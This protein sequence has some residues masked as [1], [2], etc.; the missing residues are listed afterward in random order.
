MLEDPGKTDN[1][2]V[3]KSA[4]SLSKPLTLSLSVL[5]HQNKGKYTKANKLCMVD[6][7]S[8][9][10]II[11]AEGL[12]KLTNAYYQPE[13]QKLTRHFPHASKAARSTDHWSC[14]AT[15]RDGFKVATL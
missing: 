6:M 2:Q 12:D 3:C 15:H 10:N 13:V 8:R 4:N 5:G 7:Y 14:G 11:Q 9:T 1:T